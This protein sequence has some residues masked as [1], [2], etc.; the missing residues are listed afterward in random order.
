MGSMVQEA[1]IQGFNSTSRTF[2]SVGR[3]A[4]TVSRDSAEA[5]ANS[6]RTEDD[7]EL[8]V[9]PYTGMTPDVAGGMALIRRL[10]PAAAGAVLLAGNI[11]SSGYFNAVGMSLVAGGVFKPSSASPGCRVGMVNREAAGL[12]FGGDAVGGAVI[13]AAGIRPRSSA[14]CT[15]LCF[16]RRSGETSPQS[17]FPWVRTTAR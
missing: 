17:T 2:W 5:D 8:V 16:E 10:L 12:Y 4:S 1:P 15:R 14:S 9:L 7:D 3:L 6:N 13:D 11:V